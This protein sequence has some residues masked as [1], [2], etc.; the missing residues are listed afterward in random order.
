MPS[1]GRRFLR[2]E[3]TVQSTRVLGALLR[4][5][6]AAERVAIE[7]AFRRIYVEVWLPRVESGLIVTEAFAVGGRSLR[8][9]LSDHRD[10]VTHA[11]VL[12]VVT[13]VQPRVC[14]ALALT[15]ITDL[16]RPD[17]GT[18]PP[19][20][21]TQVH[22]GRVCVQEACFALDVRVGASCNAGAPSVGVKVTDASVAVGGPPVSNH[23]I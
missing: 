9:T 22:H 17:E 20:G 7:P 12:E 21:R 18:P 1:G 11:R 8:T 3:T 6:Q 10:A 13:Q 2:V 14:S 23:R 5:P 15:R 4:G 19:T 16:F